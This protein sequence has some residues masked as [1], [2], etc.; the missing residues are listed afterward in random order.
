M[1]GENQ[2]ARRRS[3]EIYGPPRKLPRFLGICE[4]HRRILVVRARPGDRPFT[5]TDSR[6][7]RPQLGDLEM[8]IGRFRS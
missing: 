7:F 4:R 2:A 5:M 6:S 1:Y 8:V 3:R